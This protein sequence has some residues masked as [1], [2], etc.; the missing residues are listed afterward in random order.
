MIRLNQRTRFNLPLLGVMLTLLGLMVSTPLLSAATTPPVVDLNGDIPGLD[1]STTFTEDE[2]PEPIVSQ[3]LTITNSEGDSLTAAKALLFNAVDTTN[4]SLAAD[5]GLTGLTV[6]YAADSGELTIKGNGSVESYQQVLRTLVYNNGSQSPDITDRVVIIT[7]SDGS[8]N[9]LPATSTI[10]INAVNDAPVL[11]TTGNMSLIAINEDD[12]NSNGNAVTTIIKSAEAEGQDRITDADKN[13]PEGFAV[14]EAGT[15]NGVWQYSINSGLS[16]QPF[17]AVSNTSAVLLDGA[18][19]IRFVPNANYNGT[20]SF[21]FRAWDQSGGRSSGTTGVDTTENGGNTS[22]SIDIEMVTI[23]IVSVDD[24]PLIDLNGLEPGADFAVQFFEGGLPVPIADQNASIV[25][26]DHA[27]LAKVTITLVN[28]PDGNAESLAVDT[29]GTNITATTYDPI[30]GKLV[31]NGPDLIANFQEVLRRVRYNNASGSPIAGL[32]TVTSVAN[33]GISDGPPATTS[34]SVNRTNS[35]PLLDATA[36]LILPPVDEDTL[37]PVGSIISQTLAAAGN[38]ITDPD[39]GAQ[40]GIAVVGAASANGQWQ[41]SVTNPPAGEQSWLAVGAVSESAAV[42]LADTSWLRFVP[43]SNYFGESGPLTFRAWDRTSGTNGQRDVN[44]TA[45]GGNTAFSISTNTVSVLVN[46]VNDLP[47]LGQLPTEPLLYVE[48]AGP[49][50]VPGTSVTVTD[51]DSQLLASATV[52]LTNPVDGDAELLLV[53]T[54]GTGIT[55]VYEDGVLELSG[56]ASPAAYQGVLRS[57]RYWN[58]SQDPDPVDRVFQLS[59]ADNQ[60]SRPPLPIVVQVQPINDPPELDLNGVGSGEDYAATFFI[61]RGSV[62]VVS[63][64]LTVN[65]ID[66]TTLKSATIRI[67]NLK[68]PQAEILNADVAGVTN[69]K[70][71]YVPLTG[72]LTLTGVDSIANY[73]RVLRTVTYDNIL[74]S[75]DTT[76][77]EIEF[78]LNDGGSM[79][80]SR[81]TLVTMAEPARVEM[82]MSM[83]TWASRRNEE[84]N[85]SCGEAMGIG[86]NVEE[87]FLAQDKNDWFY[88]DTTGSMNISVELRDFTPGEGQIVIA[89]EN[90]PGR[91]CNGLQL[92]GNNGSNAPDKN[93]FLGRRPAG[94]YY[95]W[96]INDGVAN[97]NQTYRLFIQAEP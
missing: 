90:S 43:N 48:D 60:G 32:R 54:D 89:A 27:S 71:A 55:A 1:Y 5:A 42:L 91:G 13:S 81:K 79:S 65:D 50:P 45:N 12:Q 18:G 88:F 26:S 39:E 28:K 64:T 30:S 51:V 72:Q 22:F 74:P 59:V 94:R 96:I 21:L 25:D 52:R 68:N 40:E 34:V 23:N 37:Q 11:D 76:V 4:E 78:V 70:L 17:G 58:A 86:L 87:I 44:V 33:D 10:A 6:K 31:L 67:V 53:T 83:I 46:P 57:V 66:N 77:R 63:E 82:F 41:Y 47:V 95:I 29:T 92:I 80:A 14:I 93:V 15:A 19:R 2:G 35:A 24:L 84:P 16:W 56:A 69:I 49:L 20:A 9:S 97:T 7:V 62:S 38:P 61:N 85:N 75:P 8:Q 3:G 36:A 73:Q